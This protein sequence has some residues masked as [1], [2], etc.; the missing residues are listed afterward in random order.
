M[1]YECL[2]AFLQEG[3]FCRSLREAALECEVDD[4][5][6]EMEFIRFPR[7]C[8]KL[9][10]DIHSWTDLWWL[11]RTLRFWIVNL[12]ISI[13]RFMV[14]S[15]PFV[16][17]DNNERIA[18]DALVIEFAQAFP[19]FA[20]L[21]KLR[22]IHLNA[23]S[24]RAQELCDMMRLALSENADLSIVSYLCSFKEDFSGADANFVTVLAEKYQSPMFKLVF[25]WAKDNHVKFTRDHTEAFAKYGLL[26]E[27]KF[28]VTKFPNSFVTLNCAEKAM[29]AGQEEVIM[30]CLTYFKTGTEAHK[31]VMRVLIRSAIENGRVVFLQDNCGPNGKFR[32][33]FEEVNRRHFGWSIVADSTTYSWLVD[34]AGGAA[35]SDFP[36][37]TAIYAAKAGHADFVKWLLHNYKGEFVS[38]TSRMR[39]SCAAAEGG[40][41]QLLQWLISQSEFTHAKYPEILSKAVRGDQLVVFEWL[42]SPCGGNCEWDPV[43][44]ISDY[45]SGPKIR[46]WIVERAT[47]PSEWK[48][49]REVEIEEG[50]DNEE[51]L[52]V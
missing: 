19:E 40:Q 7:D 38:V 1:P 31:M 42:I 33:A 26:E 46:R 17:S 8:L 44:I 15:P 20:T 43:Q 28:I 49:G 23:K 41:L 51:D 34:P 48:I 39:V 47:F 37:S 3:K 10:D 27:M 6:S 52:I 22:K 9:N 24:G 16:L 36:C 32:A 35:F 5:R 13:I 14:E 30:F 18:H 45:K 4:R 50:S 25:E 2:P 29:E 21:S 12:P 11:L